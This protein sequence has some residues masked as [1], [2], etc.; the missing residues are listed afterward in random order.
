MGRGLGL[1]GVHKNGR[2]FP[3]EIS[4]SPMESPDGLLVTAAIRDISEHRKMERML[5][6]SERLASL[7]TLAAGIAHEIN[8]PISAAWS[9]AHV[10]AVPDCDAG[11]LAEEAKLSLVPEASDTHAQLYAGGGRWIWRQT[12]AL[13][14][15]VVLAAEDTARLGSL[16][17]LAGGQAE[18]A[19]GPYA[20]LWE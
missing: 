10:A 19:P 14:P 16:L 13:R 1:V 11:W 5:H 7:G 2:D 15:G 6:R 20:W 8:N 17:E 3:V 4:L 12:R 18:Q 9:A